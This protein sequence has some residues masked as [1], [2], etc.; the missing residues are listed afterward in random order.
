MCYK[1]IYISLTDTRLTYN[2]AFFMVAVTII[3]QKTSIGSIIQ[4]AKIFI[5][6]FNAVI[7]LFY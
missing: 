1:G 7:L 2:T 5:V 6:C 3:I 4:M